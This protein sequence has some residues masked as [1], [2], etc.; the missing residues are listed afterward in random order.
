[1][2]KQSGPLRTRILSHPNDLALKGLEVK[3]LTQIFGIISV[4]LF[5][6]FPVIL[7]FGPQGSVKHEITRVPTNIII[8]EQCTFEPN[9][10]TVKVGQTV[11]IGVVSSMQA[12]ALD[13]LL[14][15]ALEI[16][17]PLLGSVPTFV[18][19][20]PDTPGEYSFWC[21]ACLSTGQIQVES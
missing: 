10:A 3:T 13:S 19:V 18:E 4:I 12:S 17:T 21:S 5:I 11:R 6:M 16:S 14:I 8:S 7:G 2:E 20:T 15:P 1:M 9:V